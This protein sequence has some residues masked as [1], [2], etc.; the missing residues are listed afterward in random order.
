MFPLYP[1]H[2]KKRT[3]QEKGYPLDL[4]FVLVKPTKIYSQQLTDKGERS[5][6]LSS[7]NKYTA[8]SAAV[9]SFLCRILLSHDG[10]GGAVGSA[11]AAIHA[12]IS[13]DLVL[14][15]ALGDSLDGAVVSA[16]AAA[17]ASV[18]NLVSHDNTSK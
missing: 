3:P 17:D 7:T 14:S 18:G 1:E 10:L 11:G 5:S 16:G 15:I 12:G 2:M 8:A 6:S 13:V 4:V 9:Y